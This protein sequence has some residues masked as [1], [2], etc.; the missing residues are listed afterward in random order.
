M[1]RTR[2]PNPRR[3][4]VAP[5]TILLALAAPALLA[6]QSVAP[7][8]ASAR[9]WTLR[10]GDEQG[11]PSGWVQVRENRIA[12]T[13]L[14]LGPD[15]GVHTVASVEV[16]VRR[17][18]GP[19]SVGVTVTATTLRGSA[20]ISQPV[21]FNGTTLTAGTLLKTR[22]EAGDFLRVV[23]DYARPLARLGARGEL[24]GRVGLDATLLDF[25]LLGAI[26]PTSAGHETKEDF[27]TQELPA[28][29]VGAELRLPVSGRV[30]VRLGGDAGGL[31]WVSSLRYEGGLVH[32]TQRRLDAEAG[33]EVALARG[34]SLRAGVNATSFVQNEQSHEDGNQVSLGSTALALT[35]GW[36][37]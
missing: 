17:A 24:I 10:V 21:Y 36:Q 18:A 25:R 15:L 31:P 23:V 13:R 37:F 32:L 3:A 7:D 30:T 14:S 22:T 11:S 20:F 19:G 27:V 9:R 5:W 1:P 26:D 16:G 29:F 35:L 28:P 34:L 6:A 8:S 4:A 2:T 33:V 12:G